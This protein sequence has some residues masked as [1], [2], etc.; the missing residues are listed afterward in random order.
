M[1]I[2]VKDPSTG[3]E[4][5]VPERSSLLRRGLVRPIKG[6]RYPP[7]HYPRR[8]KHHI[9][10]PA[11]RRGAEENQGSEAPSAGQSAAQDTPAAASASAV[12]ASPKEP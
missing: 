8:A 5:D 7:S 1:Y 3:H 4:F 9:D 2:R 10:L 6:D 11:V 12:K